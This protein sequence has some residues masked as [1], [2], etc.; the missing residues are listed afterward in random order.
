MLTDKIARMREAEVTRLAAEYLHGP[1]DL[2]LFRRLP[3]VLDEDGL[4]DLAKVRT[5]AAELIATRPGLAKGAAVPS[6]GFGQGRRMP[7]DQ[8]SGVTWGAVLRGRD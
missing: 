1:G 4:V 8:G 6:R 3:D 7:V 5:V 2:L